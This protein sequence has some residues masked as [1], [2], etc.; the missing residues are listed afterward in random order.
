MWGDAFVSEHV[1]GTFGRCITWLTRVNHHDL[2]ARSTE[3]DRCGET[4]RATAEHRNVCLDYLGGVGR[5][6]RQWPGGD[7]H[8]PRG[9]DG[10]R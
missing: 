4:C 10:D 9:V 7:P 3:C 5:S 8:R 2:A 6:I 1:V